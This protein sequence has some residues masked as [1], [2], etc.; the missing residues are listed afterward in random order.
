[1]NYPD[2]GDV[3]F[4]KACN[5]VMLSQTNEAL[6]SLEKSIS[7]GT[8]YKLKAKKSKFFENLTDDPRFQSLIS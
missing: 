3:L 2:N 4:D 7:Q 5:L 1:M 8:Q 6:D